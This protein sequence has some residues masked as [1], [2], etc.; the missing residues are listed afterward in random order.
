MSRA[1]EIYTKVEEKLA[2]G[3]KRP[4]AFRELA[5][6]YGM[7][8]NSVR[9]A[10]YTHKRTLEGGGATPS[11][12]RRRETT[13]EDAVADARATLERAIASIDREVTA[14]DERAKEAVAEAKSLKELA[15]ERKKA[16]ASRLEALK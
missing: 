9:G 12:T 7:E 14:A 5:E 15:P 13:P 10:Y 8:F 2:E 4:D 6:A 11:R 1:E 3:M 16:I